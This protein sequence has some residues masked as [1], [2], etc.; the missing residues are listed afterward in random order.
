MLDLKELTKCHYDL[1]KKYQKLYDENQSLK[2]QLDS[3]E[4]N[5]LHGPEYRQRYHT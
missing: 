3:N 2:K 5:P 1:L 4:S